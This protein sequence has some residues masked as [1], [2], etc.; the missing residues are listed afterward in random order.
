MIGK[1]EKKKDKTKHRVNHDNAPER[2]PDPQNDSRQRKQQRPHPP[3]PT[4][5]ST[6]RQIRAS[7]PAL[8]SDTLTL[9][10]LAYLSI[11][12]AVEGGATS[13]FF[14]DSIVRLLS[15]RKKVRRMVLTRVAWQRERLRR[16]GRG[17][18]DRREGLGRRD[19]CVE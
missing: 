7:I 17:G 2:R 18:A 10:K 6:I 3:A 11:I 8:P 15:G 5:T 13:P 1:A 9:Q 19:S 12:A 14:W 4:T 16:E